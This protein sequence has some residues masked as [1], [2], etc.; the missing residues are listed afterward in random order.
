[1][2][3]SKLSEALKFSEAR[4]KLFEGIDSNEQRV[5]H[6][7]VR[8][9]ASL[10]IFIIIIIIIIIERNLRLTRVQCLIS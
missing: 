2:T 3:V 9:P 5:H 7:E 6:T 8:M 10:N 4:I 1:M